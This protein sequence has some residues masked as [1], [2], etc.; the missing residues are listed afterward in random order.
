MGTC[1]KKCL[2]K[3]SKGKENPALLT[4]S[5]FRPRDFYE[6]QTDKHSDLICLTQTYGNGCCCGFPPRFPYP[7]TYRQSNMP[8]N[9]FKPND[10]RLFFCFSIITYKINSFKQKL[11]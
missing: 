2:L 6:S 1:K 10:L 9:G 11:N 3:H 7:Q 4:I 5:P 8:D